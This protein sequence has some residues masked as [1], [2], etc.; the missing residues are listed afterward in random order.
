MSAVEEWTGLSS[1]PVCGRHL[2]PLLQ[3]RARRLQAVCLG[4]MSGRGG[5]VLVPGF[6]GTSVSDWTGVLAPGGFLVA[7]VREAL[8]HGADDK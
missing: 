1:E 8:S 4:T 2:S 6:R 3:L 7:L 5:Y